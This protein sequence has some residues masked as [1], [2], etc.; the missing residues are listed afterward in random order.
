MSQSRQLAAIMFTDIVGY[1]ALMEQDEKKAFDVLKKNLDIH[2]SIINEFRGRLIKEMGDGMLASFPTVSDALNAAIQIQNQCNKI[3]E[4]KLSIGIHQGEVVFQNN[5]V[6]GDAVNV[7]SRIQSLGSAGSILFSK[8]ITDEIKNKA[9]FQTV[10][11]GS[12]EFKNVIEPIE[13]FALANDGFPIPKKNR[14]QGKLKNRNFQKQKVKYAALLIL[15][16]ALS[17][18]I[19]YQFIEFQNKRVVSEIRNSSIAILPF[20]NQTGRKELNSIGQVAADFISTNLIQ[21]Q[22]WKVISTQE[23]FRQT[24]YAGV[25]TNPEAERKILDQ[26]RVDFLVVGHYNLIGDSVLLVASVNDVTDNKILYTTPIIK[27][28]VTDPMKA[29]NAVQQFILGYLMF[30]R[31]DEKHL[32]TRPPMYDAYQEYLKGMEGWTK[33][34]LGPGNNYERKDTE[35]ER[36]FKN[37]ISMDVDFLPPYFKLAEF[38]SID[39]KFKRLDSILQILETKKKLFLEGDN[40]NFTIQKLLLSKDWN[41]LENFLLTKTEVGTSD[42]RPYYLLAVN[43]LYRQN[44]PY[45]A[46]E[47]ISR[48]DLREYDF[49]NK[50]SDQQLYSVQASA[51]IKL[52]Q[53]EKVE[54]LTS[55]FNFK[56]KD[57][58]ILVKRWISLYFLNKKELADKEVENFL[59]TAKAAD[60]IPA[61]SL[62]RVAQ[63]QGDTIS[64]F[65]TYQRFAQF[66]KQFDERT[67]EKTLLKFQLAVMMYK[68][69]DDIAGAEKILQQN[70]PVVSRPRRIHQLGIFYAGTDREEKANEIIQNLL[71]H[72]KSFDNGL[73]SYYAAKIEAELGHKEKSVEYLRQAIANGIEFRQELFEFDA[74]LKILLDY[75]PF[76][77]LVRPNE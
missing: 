55:N 25:S 58:E 18:V 77:E 7:A 61:I 72:E 29:V 6:F 54:E 52:R 69:K 62:F 47:Y 68:S 50:R 66:I 23:V 45:K 36:N 43:A 33:D 75:P 21:N 10:S 37:S 27:C 41:A 51:L 38:Y 46:L 20:E 57:P 53:F 56:I 16:I 35:I 74:D 17:I 11:L 34:N 12:F 70:L 26:S 65:K 14:I 24:V 30:S 49:E 48:C 63:L 71:S 15:T 32:T 2:Q 1:T 42:F 19:Y 40:L 9:E 4:Y 31:S 44:K 73:P 67:L 13:V 64:M 22:F 39:R 5:D 28:I 59:L 3:N 76:I 60:F 8:K